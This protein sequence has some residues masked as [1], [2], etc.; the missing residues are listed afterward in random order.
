MKEHL[1]ASV[2]RDNAGDLELRKR[3]LIRK[4]ELLLKYDQDVRSAED[5]FSSM[6]R[7]LQSETDWMTN[8]ALSHVKRTIETLLLI[9]DVPAEVL[10][11]VEA[12]CHL[13]YQSKM[14]AKAPPPVQAAQPQETRGRLRW[15]FRLFRW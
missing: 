1:S 3:I 9:G 4:I 2:D 13:Q 12:K 7:T 10:D 14:N 8:T 5:E 15:L 11:G 6:L